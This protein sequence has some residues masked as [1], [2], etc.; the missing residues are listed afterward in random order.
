MTA[1]MTIQGPRAGGP[2][3]GLTDG[4][5][6]ILRCS[7]CDR[8]LCDVFITLPNAKD[9]SGNP[10]QWRVRATCAY[11]CLKPDGTP[12]TSFVHEFEGL[13][14]R[15]GWGEDNP[16]DPDDSLMKTA[17]VAEPFESDADGNPV[18]TFVTKRKAQK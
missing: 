3:V 14:C 18:L 1:K 4:G 12:E 13:F 6:V 11:G 8:P 16:D 17:I 15:G 9:R 10:Y 2:P 7:N 5:H